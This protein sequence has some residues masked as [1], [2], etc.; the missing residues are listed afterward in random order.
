[1]PYVVCVR[2]GE[3]GTG[4]GADVAFVCDSRAPSFRPLTVRSGDDAARVHDAFV[5][6]DG[7]RGFYD[8]PGFRRLKTKQKLNSERADA[9]VC[10]RD[11]PRSGLTACERNSSDRRRD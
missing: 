6:G 8:S 2:Y 5:S 7:V 4:V 3:L 1:M 11:A 9:A 10:L